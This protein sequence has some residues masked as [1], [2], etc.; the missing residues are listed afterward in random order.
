MV[1]NIWVNIRLCRLTRGLCFVIAPE[2]IAINEPTFA[3]LAGQSF[4][5]GGGFRITAAVVVALIVLAV[6]VYLLHYTRFG[7]TVYAIGGESSR[8][9]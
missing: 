8:R 6:A 5:F 1:D 4:A 7:R 2:S 3:A 9:S